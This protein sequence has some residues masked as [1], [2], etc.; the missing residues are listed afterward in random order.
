VE[1]VVVY[2][3][4]LSQNL[5][6]EAEGNHERPQPGSVSPGMCLVLPSIA[7]HCI[8]KYTVSSQS[9]CRFRN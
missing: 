5:L 3:K 4:V 1:M 2:F 7:D 6:V 8:A 9:L